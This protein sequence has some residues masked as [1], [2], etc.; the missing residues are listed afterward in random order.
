MNAG[1]SGPHYIASL[2]EESTLPAV[3]ERRC[4]AT[5]DDRFATVCGRTVTFGEMHTRAHRAAAALHAV[6]V[7]RGA[8]VAV[9]LQNCL[10][11]MDLWFGSASLGAVLVPINT[12][13]RGSGLRYIAEHSDA[14]VCFVDDELAENFDAAVPA[15]VGPARRFVRA[16][17][18]RAGW[19]ALSELYAD[20]PSSISLPDVQPGDLASLLYTS[21]TTGLPKGAR[22]CQN[23]YVG[24][25]L[26]YSQRWV[27]LRADDILWT[28]LPLVHINAQALTTMG[29]LL[30][31]CPMVM[32]ARFSGS[33]FLDEVRGCG[34]TVFNYMGAILTIL[35]KQPLRP[36]D[37]E[38]P[39]RISIGSS[40]PPELWRPFEQRFGLKLI[41]IYGLTETAGV[42]LASPHDDVRIGKCGVPVTWSEVQIQRQDGS[43]ADVDEP[44]E[45]VIRSKRP[46]MMFKGYH[47]QADYVE[48][49]WFHSGDRG[50]RSADGYFIFI[51]RLKDSVRRRGE[52][53]SSFE[54][55]QVIN[56]HPAVAECAVVGVP[57]D[58][59][60]E[61]VLV[62][63]VVRPDFVLDPAELVAFC[64]NHMAAFMVPRYV[65]VVDRLPK[66]ATEKIQKFAIRE[67]KTE[68]AWDSAATS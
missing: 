44:G 36:D 57:S 34:A 26:E 21:G 63:V 13:L 10:E 62:E 37:A 48:G 68:G 67:K 6:G 30:S 7:R 20:A 11:F 17:A 60:E 1:T 38:T 52:N 5:P 32:T 46:N 39:L 50:R 47:K 25:G 22:T 14:S 4:N 65:R 40:A 59:S 58:L 56:T 3:L 23:A 29:S 33:G 66:T 42:A 55:E 45:F 19:A 8:T 43:E 24:T 16:E 9:M 53:I 2:T 18:S 28:C 49:E 31:G 27:Q 15:G 61:E 12:Q 54:V 51:D 41:E 35:M 64:R